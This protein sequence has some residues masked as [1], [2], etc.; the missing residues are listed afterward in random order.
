MSVSATAVDVD[1]SSMP[2]LL[3]RKDIFESKFSL[4]INSKQ[5]ITVLKAN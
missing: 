5:K 3:G 2:L 1:G 4:E